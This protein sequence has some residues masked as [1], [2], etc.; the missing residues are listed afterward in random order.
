[1]VENVTDEIII[2]FRNLIL[3]LS[4]FKSILATTLTLRTVRTFCVERRGMVVIG[5]EQASSS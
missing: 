5:D 1:M 3:E 2:Q 4:G